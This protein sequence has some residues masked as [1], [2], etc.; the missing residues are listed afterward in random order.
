MHGVMKNIAHLCTLRGS[1]IWGPDGWQKVVVCIVADGRKQ[2]D[3]RVLSILATLGVYQGGIAKNMVNDK[4]VKAH[5]YEV[6]VAFFFSFSSAFWI[7]VM[8]KY[9][10][11]DLLIV[12]HTIVCRP[13]FEL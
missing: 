12:Y 10:E 8:F 9:N 3:K 1:P 7:R 5:I 13:Q 6:S 11:S 4:P 2:C